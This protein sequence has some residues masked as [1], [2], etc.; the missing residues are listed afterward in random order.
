MYRQNYT[1]SGGKVMGKVTEG[2]TG[3]I[4]L[5]LW[6]HYASSDLWQ[7]YRCSVISN[8]SIVVRPSRSPTNY[9][10]WRD[11]KYFLLIKKSSNH[12]VP[13]CLFPIASS[14]FPK[15]LVIFEN[16][17]N[18]YITGE[19]LQRFA[20]RPR[21]ILKGVGNLVPRNKF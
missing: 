2:M 8:F 16:W 9:S 14:L 21:Y 12:S 11:K 5:L 15:S 4:I 7:L 20:Y 1:S 19:D 6:K 18:W 10:N 17:Y 3:S 13:Y